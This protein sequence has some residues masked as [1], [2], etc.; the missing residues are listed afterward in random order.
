M[1]QSREMKAEHRVLHISR[2]GFVGGVE[3]VMLTL[4]SSMSGR[5]QPVIVCPGGDALE[6]EARQ[7]GVEVA[8]QPINRMRIAANPL[9]MAHYPVSLLRTS[10]RIEALCRERQVDVIHA[11]HPISVLYARRAARS[12][13][14][15]I[16]FH[17]HEA[18]PGKALYMLALRAAVRAATRIVCVSAA[19]KTFLEEAGPD[20]DKVSIVYNGVSQVF[21]DAADARPAARLGEGPHVATFGVLEPRKGQDVFLEAAG[22]VRERYPA[23]KFWIVGP[24]ALQDKAWF[25]D[26]LRAQAASPG[27]AGSVTFTGYRTD[28]IDLMKAMDVVVLASV[29]HES[30]GMV[31]IE[32]MTLGRPVVGSRIGGMVEVIRDGETG[33]LAAPRN[34]AELATRII[35]AIGK[36]GAAMAAQARHEAARRFSPDAFCGQFE[37]IYD[38][39]LGALRGGNLEMKERVG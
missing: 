14:V 22:L 20:P 1:H 31:L 6:A 30:L 12:L 4:A 10:R 15:P 24:A 25:A 21:L 5:Y 38:D 26:Q 23:A 35:Q 29:A 17:F 37:Q 9:A 33:A 28:V 34:P 8:P 32:A 36:K 18:G 2:V 19:A 7:C 3:R 39:A 11:H 13:G 27:L 16:I